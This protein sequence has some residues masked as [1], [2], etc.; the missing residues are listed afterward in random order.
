MVMSQDGHPASE[1]VAEPGFT[2]KSEEGGEE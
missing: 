1:R 2:E